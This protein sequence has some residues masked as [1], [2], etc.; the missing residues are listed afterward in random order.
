M[1]SSRPFIRERATGPFFY[2]KWSRNGQPVIRALGRAW[3]EPDG[4]GGWRRKRGRAPEGVMTE[5]EAAARMLALIRAHHEEQTLLERDAEERRRRGVTVR[6]LAGEYLQWLADVKSAKPS[7]LRDH[8]SLLAEPGQAYRRGKGACRGLI[9]AALGDRPAREV[10]TREVEDLLRSI[11]S[12]G[13]APRTVNKARQ[14]ICAIFNYGMRR[15]TYA[16]TVTRL[17]MPIAVASRTPLHWRSI[18]LRRSRRWQERWPTVPT[19]MRHAPR[20]PLPRSQLVLTRTPRTQSSSA[21]P[22]T[23]ASV[24]E[25]SSHFAGATSTSPVGR[26]SSVERCL[27]R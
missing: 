16:L 27:A 24:V 20:F 10:T 18:H 22:P 4:G 21:W 13:V 11:A 6:E 23:P 25:S 9:M 8:R 15:S 14:L 2:G 5:T 7:T 3:V 19:V 17:T 12:T 1:T 26:S